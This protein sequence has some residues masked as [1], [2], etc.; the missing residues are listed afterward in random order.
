MNTKDI[1]YGDWQYDT[2]HLRKTHYT[3][4]FGEAI[5]EPNAGPQAS[6]IDDLNAAITACGRPITTNFIR[7]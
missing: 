3:D 4:E 5:V 1:Y 2:L 7:G 6:F